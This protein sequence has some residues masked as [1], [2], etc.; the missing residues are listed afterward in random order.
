MRDGDIVPRAL[1][2]FVRGSI[3]VQLTSYLTGLDLAKKV[4]LLFIKHK[5]SSWIQT[6][7]TGGQPY[8]DTS[9]FYAIEYVCVRERDNVPLVIFHV[10]ERELLLVALLPIRKKH[11]SSSETTERTNERNF[12]L[13]ATC[14][15]NCQ[16]IVVSVLTQM[17]TYVLARL[18]PTYRCCSVSY[19]VTICHKGE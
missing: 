19:L 5:Q 3:S 10:W 17:C 18:P 4:N 2:Y 6:G 14:S 8:S 12:L 13:R 1:T 7:Q 16:F 15:S 11:F 9:P